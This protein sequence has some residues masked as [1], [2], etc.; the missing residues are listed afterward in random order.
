MTEILPVKFILKELLG[1]FHLC[2]DEHRA[3]EAESFERKEG[4]TMAL[5]RVMMIVREGDDGAREGDDD[6]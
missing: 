3:V 2:L 5:E 6:C 4:E 1:C